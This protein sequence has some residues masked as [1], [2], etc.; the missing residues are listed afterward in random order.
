MGF[1]ARRGRRSKCWTCVQCPAIRQGAGCRGGGAGDL[2]PT[3]PCPDSVSPAPFPGTRPGPGRDSGVESGYQ[4]GGHLP[5]LSGPQAFPANSQGPVA[6]PGS[7]GGG[8]R[9]N[10]MRGLRARGRDADPGRTTWTAVTGGRPRGEVGSA[11]APST[12]LRAS[13]AGS[14]CFEPLVGGPR[15]PRVLPHQTHPGARS[16]ANNISSKYF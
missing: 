3:P 15:M 7:G 2:P 6:L 9:P 1:K 5:C 14:T 16:W 8:P 11:R 13:R 4:D 10:W 12:G